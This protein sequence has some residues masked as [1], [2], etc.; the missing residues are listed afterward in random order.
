[1]DSIKKGISPFKDLLAVLNDPSNFE[2]AII[3][4]NALTSAMYD[5]CK[6]MELIGEKDISIL[7]QTTQPGAVTS[8]L[9]SATVPVDTTVLAEG[10]N[11]EGAPSAEQM[12]QGGVDVPATAMAEVVQQVASVP[13]V[14]TSGGGAESTGG[15]EAKLDE[16]I[17]LMKSGKIG[18]SMDGKKVEKTLARAAP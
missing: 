3:G 1:M 2:G 16:L 14:V 9:A 11:A 15:V 7:Q 10:S 18:V 5:L 6:V 4:L 17:S 12:A 8:D 13:S